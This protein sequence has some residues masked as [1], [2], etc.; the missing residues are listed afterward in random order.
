MELRAPL[1]RGSFR[2]LTAAYALNELGDWLADLIVVLACCAFAPA[3]AVMAAA[4]CAAL[5]A[6]VS[7]AGAQAGLPRRGQVSR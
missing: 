6:L 2:R 7:L 4:L 1:R 5:P 3:A